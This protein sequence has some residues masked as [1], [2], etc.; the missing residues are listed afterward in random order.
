MNVVEGTFE[1]DIDNHIPLLFGH[2][3]HKSVFCD[4]CIVYK[5]VKLSKLLDNIFHN[6]VGI[7]ERGCV[8]SQG[9][10]L[11]TI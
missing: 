1:V 2:P 9:K 11:D 8:G 6:F 5:D 10:D 4:P 7:L 3:H